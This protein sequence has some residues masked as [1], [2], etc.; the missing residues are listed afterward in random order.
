MFVKKP[1]Q[2]QLFAGGLAGRFVK[3]FTI[4]FEKTP[5]WMS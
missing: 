2:N 3:G 4:S 1:L 5:T